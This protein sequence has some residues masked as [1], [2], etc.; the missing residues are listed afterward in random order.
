[1]DYTI[2]S[3]AFKSFA[4]DLDYWIDSSTTCFTE[5]NSNDDEGDFKEPEDRQTSSLTNIFADT[6][7]VSASSD[8]L[9]R[10][11][12][13][14]NYDKALIEDGDQYIELK[15]S[16][17]FYNINSACKHSTLTLS[18]KLLLLPRSF[19][20]HKVQKWMKKQYLDQN[21]ELKKNFQCPPSRCNINC[22]YTEPP[23]VNDELN[24]IS[25][26][27]MRHSTDSTNCKEVMCRFCHGRNWVKT[28]NYFKH[29]VLAHGIMTQVKPE[30]LDSLTVREFEITDYFIVK[31]QT[32]YLNEF[33][34][35]LLPYLKVSFIPIP[36]RYYSK[37]I[38]GGFRRT[39]VMCPKCSKW[40]RIGWCEHDEIIKEVYED[41]DSFRNF[42]REDYSKISYIQKRDR[43]S[44]EGI[45]ENYFTH[46]IEC[47]FTKFQ[48]KCLY[49]QVVNPSL[50]IECS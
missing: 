38:N 10:K 29:L 48:S 21:Y 39:H 8:S 30:Y 41:F 12:S 44:I 40:I 14:T 24:W 18:N 2:G 42:N 25:Y 49:V 1:M 15:N 47:D 9:N 43:S 50:A 27:F 34:R 17:S 11:T 7:N 46:Y 6:T 36:N 23:G 19:Q 5:N 31:M 37:I 45:Y 3:R 22:N 33:S 35:N 26:R 13:K 32:I 20:H 28:A 16:S 4:N